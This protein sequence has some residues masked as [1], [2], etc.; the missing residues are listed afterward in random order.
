MNKK[1]GRQKIRQLRSSRIIS[2][3]LATFILSAGITSLLTVVLNKFS[4]LPYALAVILFPAVF[5]FMA[6]LNRFWAITEGDISKLLNERHPQLEESSQ[7]FLKDPAQLN[8]L[9]KLQVSKIEPQLLVLKS[10]KDLR[11]I[12]TAPAIVFLAALI[13]S[14]AFHQITLGS[15][16]GDVKGSAANKI[17][18]K[19]KILPEIE[20]V[21]ITIV[22]PAYTGKK[23]RQQDE[24]SLEAEEGAGVTWMLETTTPVRELRIILNNHSTQAF[25]AGNTQR[26]RWIFRSRV[27]APGFYQI[28]LDGKLSDLYKIGVIRDQTP[29]IRIHS[30]QQSTVIDFGEPQ[31][32]ALHAELTDDYAIS[33]ASIHA[34]LA[35][36]K[37]E[38]V[39]FK[40]YQ[41][42]FRDFIANQRN[43]RLKQVLGLAR[44]GMKPGDELYFYISATDN[45]RQEK[46]SDIYI[47]TMADTTQLLSMEGLSSGVNLMPEYFRSQRQII[48]DTERLLREKDTIATEDFKNRSN[49]LGMDQKLLRLRYGKFLGEEFESEIGGDGHDHEE[50]T[51]FGDAQSMID[52]VSHKHDNS[53]DATFFEPQQKAQLKAVLT[54]MWKAEL[55]LRTLKPRAALPFEYKALRLLKD[56]Q[57][58]SRAYVGKTGIKTPALKPDKRLT[59]ELEEIASPINQHKVQKDQDPNLAV[60]QAIGIL[61]RLKHRQSLS[62]AESNTLQ[63]ANLRLSDA[64]A[65]QPNRYLPALQAM[66]KVMSGVDGT[67]DPKVIMRIQTAFHDLLKE[68]SRI[69]GQSKTKENALSKEYFRM[70]N[71]K[72]K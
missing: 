30:P 17:A 20:S 31:Q 46:R 33:A 58:K 36:G 1:M 61:D 6:Y 19:E 15:R 8:R 57:Q 25:T 2:M 40:E 16:K 18:P 37:G 29:Q 14:F 42:S 62:Q 52:A 9:E 32:V 23:Q 12:L 7:L 39:A 71:K 66:Q 63:A 22:P 69:P 51:P 55:Q 28:R 70:L 67:R 45:H 35:S 13:L 21:S 4:S 38:S 53:E 48:L 72:M 26:T 56:L 60:R 64:A 54:E 11:R 43:L 59:G 49:E 44:M 47:V 10:T 3:F 50:S 24:F 34:T 27:Q 65:S 41:L 68:N 5:A